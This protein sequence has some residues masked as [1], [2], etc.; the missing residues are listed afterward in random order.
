MSNGLLLAIEKVI[1]AD[2]AENIMIHLPCLFDFPL[3]ITTFLEPPKPSHPKIRATM[4]PAA[5]W[6]KNPLI[7]RY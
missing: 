2:I 3:C 6:L 5:I 1:I 4:I 7:P